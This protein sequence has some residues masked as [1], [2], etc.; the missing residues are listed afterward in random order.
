M[1]EKCCDMYPKSCIPGCTSGEG[2][3]FASVSGSSSSSGSQSSGSGSSSG[4]SRRLFDP[5]DFFS[6][7]RRNLL[8]VQ[9]NECPDG[10]AQFIEQQALHQTHTIIF[11]IAMMHIVL[12]VLLLSVTTWRVKKWTRWERYGDQPGENVANLSIPPK[13]KGA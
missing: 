5:D 13:R 10:Q 3:D 11:Y 4:S 8:Q 6:S 9:V 1:A 7:F 12:G 2:C